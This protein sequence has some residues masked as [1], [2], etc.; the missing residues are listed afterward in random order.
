MSARL[1]DAPS[2][3][4]DH[5]AR[6]GE[7]RLRGLEG[8]VR[9]GEVLIEAKE[10]LVHGDWQKLCRQLPFSERHAHRLRSIAAH[11]VLSNRTLMSDLPDD[12]MTLYI[13]SRL[14]PQLVEQAIHDH[15]IHARMSVGDARALAGRSSAGSSSGS[16]AN[17]TG[18][19]RAPKPWRIADAITKIKKI[20]APCPNWE[21]PFLAGE[22]RGLATLLTPEPAKPS[23]SARPPR[24]KPDP[25]M[26]NELITFCVRSATMKWHPDRPTGTARR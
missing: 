10:R 24:G 18:R 2:T 16:G 12:L 6:I 17:G 20:I 19:S 21:R 23:S 13:L 7:I 25:A 1:A 5:P 11:P 8:L 14:D 26:V 9:R 4:G 15:R 22:L 3:V